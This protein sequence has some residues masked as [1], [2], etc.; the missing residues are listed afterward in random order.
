[1]GPA[2]NLRRTLNTPAAVAGEEDKGTRIK[3][4]KRRSSGW[5][6]MKKNKLEVDDNPPPPR[7]PPPPQNASN[8]NSTREGRRGGDC[9]EERRGDGFRRY[10]SLDLRGEGKKRIIFG[11]LRGETEIFAGKGKAVERR[12]R[13]CLLQRFC[14]FFCLNVILCFYNYIIIKGVVGNIRINISCFNL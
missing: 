12:R 9:Y 10:S 4:K 11:G 5:E 3:S 1:M 2:P 7:P 13:H 14:F 6:S 8:A